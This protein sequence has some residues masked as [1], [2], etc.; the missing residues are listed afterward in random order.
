MSI[1]LNRPATGVMTSP[2][3]LPLV[4]FFQA[5][6]FMTWENLITDFNWHKPTQHR[7]PAGLSLSLR[8][9]FGR[10]V[11]KNWFMLWMFWLK[12]FI[13]MFST[14]VTLDNGMSCGPGTCHFCP[15]ATLDPVTSSWRTKFLWI[16]LCIKSEHIM[17]IWRLKMVWA[18]W[19]KKYDII[20]NSWQHT[21]TLLCLVTF[22][23]F[24][25]HRTF[26]MM[27]ITSKSCFP[28]CNLINSRSGSAW[29]FI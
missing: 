8:Q 29:V 9:P 28:S 17:V 24:T 3:F 6:Q 7:S 11:L 25:G 12:K 2:C 20:L 22:C 19:L 16:K 23:Y 26:I 4:A 1:I 15:L 21:H 14:I 5:A 10:S 27:M 18:D 13:C